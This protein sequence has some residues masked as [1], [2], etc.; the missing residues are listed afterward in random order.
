MKYRFAEI[1]E[2]CKAL[3]L[4]MP[5]GVRTDKQETYVWLC[6]RV[7][8]SYGMETV[9]ISPEVS[10]ACFMFMR[11]NHV[12]LKASVDEHVSISSEVAQ[13]SVRMTSD[14]L[15][16]HP[17]FVKES[18]DYAYRQHNVEDEMDFLVNI[19]CTSIKDTIRNLQFLE[20]L[21]KY[22][23]QNLELQLTFPASEVLASASDRA[24]AQYEDMT[25][26][27]ASYM[28]SRFRS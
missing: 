11:L 2:R 10:N 5:S 25:E 9:P 26:S 21:K 8:E 4:E 6:M 1:V 18:L 7:M 24:Q 3:E 19:H 12:D 22:H 14:T 16:H 27:L 20:K 13:Y 23:F 15:L 17:V 28:R